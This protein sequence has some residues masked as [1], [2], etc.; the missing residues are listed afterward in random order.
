MGILNKNIDAASGGTDSDFKIN[1]ET[2]T[3][4][5]DWL[6]PSSNLTLQT[7][8]FQASTAITVIPGKLSSFKML[9]DLYIQSNEAEL[10]LATG[11]VAVEFPENIRLASSNI[12][13]VENG[14]FQGIPV[15]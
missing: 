5:M 4:L 11:S 13:H 9:T 3:E 6:S 7:M 12:V 14:S 1:D 2:M 10:V 8:M 15:D